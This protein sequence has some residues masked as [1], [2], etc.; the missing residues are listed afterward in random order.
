MPKSTGWSAEFLAWS[1]A[2]FKHATNYQVP[3]GAQKAGITED[4]LKTWYLTILAGKSDDAIYQYLEHSQDKA[5]FTT[6]LLAGEFSHDVATPKAVAKLQSA[7]VK[8]SEDLDAAN[9]RI[10]VLTGALTAANVEVPI[11]PLMGPSGKR[12]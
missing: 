2:E 9:D 4:A 5:A 12:D 8:L 10:E 1:Q 6:A 7:N 3:E 11:D